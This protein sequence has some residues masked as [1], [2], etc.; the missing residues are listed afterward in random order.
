MAKVGRPTKA[1]QDS[2]DV[3]R[4]LI[5]SAR[6][7]FAQEKYEKLTIRVIAENAGVNSALI[8][9]HFENKLGL[10]KTMMFELVSEVD[11]NVQQ[12]L[13]DESFKP[14]YFFQAYNQAMLK[15][16]NFP[17]LM[18]NELVIGD[19][20]CRQELLE[21]IEA[22]LISSI[23]EYREVLIEHSL[24]SPDVDI[25]QFRLMILSLCLGPWILQNCLKSLEDIDYT[26]EFVSKISQ[27][28]EQL[29]SQGFLKS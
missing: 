25:I 29:F 18:I 28:Q 24:I 5:N 19:G 17:L 14:T 27:S 13:Q 16:P 7:L 2:R 3:R 20:Y 6:E 9:Y 23:Q 26:G 22:T 15:T 10:Y 4:A 21:H 11:H 12:G 1:N 8:N